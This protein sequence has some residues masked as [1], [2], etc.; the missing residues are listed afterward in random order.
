MSIPFLTKH[1]ITT[2]TTSP[3]GSILMCHLQILEVHCNMCKRYL[4]KWSSE[5]ELCD[6]DDEDCPGM[7]KTYHRVDNNGE[8]CSACKNR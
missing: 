3:Q 8:L 5:P 7:R 1:R 4:Y 6:E 2:F